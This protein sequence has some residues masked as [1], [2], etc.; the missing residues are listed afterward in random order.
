MKRVAFFVPL[1]LFSIFIHAQKLTTT[2]DRSTGDTV[3]STGFDTL[4]A[5]AKNAV[6]DRVVGVRTV[7][8]GKATYW[9]FFYFSTSD[10]TNQ[11]VNISSKNFAY[12]VLNND[13]YLRFPY[14]GRTNKYAPSDNAGFFI[15]ITKYISQLRTADIK[16]IRFETS[17]YY[18]EIKLSG[19]ENFK[20]AG[21]IN[22]LAK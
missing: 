19:K 2:V 21:I 12:F 6:A 15:D 16:I 22:S 13:T 14:S 11:S 10:I 18:H 3:V 17:T 20:I 9:L 5:V 7:H 4:Q 8:K 1:F